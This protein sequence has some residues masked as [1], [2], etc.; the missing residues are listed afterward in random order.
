VAK[1]R[2]M[3]RIQRHPFATLATVVG[4]G[5]VVIVPVAWWTLTGPGMLAPPN[6][7]AGTGPDRPGQPAEMLERGEAPSSY[8]EPP[9]GERLARLQ[10]ALDAGQRA[11]EGNDLL[12]ARVQFSAALRAGPIDPQATEIRAKLVKLANQT[13][14]SPEHFKG[15]PHTLM[16]LVQK[17]DTLSKI[18]KA[19]KVTPELIARINN[20]GDKTIIREGARLKV[21]RGPFNAV[22]RKREFVM[23]V[24]LDD[25]M[26]RTYKVGLG[27]HGST[28]TGTWRIKNKLLNPSY[29][30]PRGG[31]IIQADDPNNPLGEHWLGLEGVAGE[32][33]NQE[34]YGIHGTNEPNSI[35]KEMSLG[36][37][38][39]HNADVTELYMLLVIGD[40]QV[41]VTE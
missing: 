39:L 26:V 18:A 25:I 12:T 7:Q 5:L 14:F 29:F 34:R 23:D 2:F 6:E 17:G 27:E 9:T 19:H 28:P 4:L 37:I 21:V 38:R 24:F 10:A 16:Y 20:L 3:R 8:S 1:T 36:C 30:P 22:V 15:D 40:S 31:K 35:G 33:K 13:I 32:A 11:L 41:T